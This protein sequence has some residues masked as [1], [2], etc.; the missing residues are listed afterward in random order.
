MND[1]QKHV[2]N[3]AVAKAVTAAEMKAAS[4]HVE[5]G[6][7]TLKANINLECTL[8]KGQDYET[9]VPSKVNW[10]LLAA[11]F[12]S[13]VRKDTLQEIYDAYRKCEKRKKFDALQEKI[14]LD[15]QTKL[16]KLVKKTKTQA[17]GKV[18]VEDVM[19]EIKKIKLTQISE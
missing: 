15:V 5:A 10:R 7:Y 4:S 3:L 13:R 14:K 1:L 19:L 11:L 17:N 6:Q 8:Q 2:A 9:T 16:D 18:S 12:A